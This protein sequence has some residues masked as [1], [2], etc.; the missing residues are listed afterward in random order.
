MP[1]AINAAFATIRL[2]QPSKAAGSRRRGSCRHADT[3]ASWV[4]SAAS[5]SLARIDQAS[6]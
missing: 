1:R 3:S 5:A 2:S 4:A 6:R